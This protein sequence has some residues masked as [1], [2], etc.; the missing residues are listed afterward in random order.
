V[1]SAAAW[2]N[3]ILPEYQS[4]KIGDWVPMASK[5]NETTA[6][7]MVGI[8]PNQSMLWQKP[9]STWAWELVPLEGTR[10]RLITRI[11]AHYE[12]RRSPGNAVLSLILLEFGDLPMRFRGHAWNRSLEMAAAMAVPASHFAVSLRR[13]HQRLD[14]RVLLPLSF[15]AIVGVMVYRGHEYT[16]MPATP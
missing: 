12:W 4:P 14:L 10:T 8:E 5:I 6:F 16:Q 7:K 3:T 15:V 11:K 9:G 13:R 2:P 1:A